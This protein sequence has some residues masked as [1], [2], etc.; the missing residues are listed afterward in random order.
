[1]EHMEHGLMH[2]YGHDVIDTVKIWGFCGG[3]YEESRL[4]GSGVVWLLVLTRA[5]RRHNSE[6][7]IFHNRKFF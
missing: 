2:E 1:M 6:D 4:L 3:D 5:T 7:G